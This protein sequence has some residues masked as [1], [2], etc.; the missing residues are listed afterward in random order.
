MYRGIVHCA[1]TLFVCVMTAGT[2]TGRESAAA[3][4]DSLATTAPAWF[5]DWNT[6]MAV[7][8]KEKKPVVVDFFSDGCGACKAMHENVFTDAAVKERL[9]PSWVCISVN[10]SHGWKSGVWDGESMRYSG[11]AKHF[12][13][14]GVPTFLFID[15]EGTPVQSVVGYK[16]AELFCDILDFFAEEAYEKGVTFK[17]FRQAR[18]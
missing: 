8:R 16:N 4:T 10:T 6:G 14:R 9:A 2:V 11:L 1:A 17:V 15:R 3:A 13:V 18:R 7:A 5:D 12:R